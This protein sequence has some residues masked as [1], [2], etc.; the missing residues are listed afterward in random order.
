MGLFGSFK[1]DITFPWIELHSMIDLEK[2][3]QEETDDLKVF[4][5]HSTRCSIS[6]MAL[7][8]FQQS[9]NKEMS[10]FKL[11]FIDLLTHRDISNKIADE[12][13]VNHQSPQ[14]IVLKNNEVVYTASHEQISASK[15][16]RIA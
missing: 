7:R 12:M 1:P 15:I 9:W 11:Y 13:N 8:D 2:A 16:Q 4:F 6:T 14:V 3:L 10:G 5:K